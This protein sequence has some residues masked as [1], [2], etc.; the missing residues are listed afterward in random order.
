[1]VNKE[2]DIHLGQAVD[3]YFLKLLVLETVFKFTDISIYRMCLN[4][5]N[6]LGL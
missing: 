2:T 3:K 5:T 6:H 4:K 1:M